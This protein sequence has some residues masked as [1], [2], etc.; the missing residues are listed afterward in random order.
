MRSYH[1]IFFDLDGTLMDTSIGV[2]QAIDFI[3]DRFKLPPLSEEEKRSFIGPPIQRSFQKKYGFDEVQ[4]WEIASA[5]RNA[6]KDQFLLGAAPYDG[7][8]DLLEYCQDKGIHT[9][10]ATNKREDYTM[11]LLQHF[12][13]TPLFDCIV[14]SDF[15]GKRTK[16]QMIQM[17]VEEIG[18]SKPGQCLMVGDTEEDGIAAM[19]AGVDFVGV[20]YGFGILP[21]QPCQTAKPIALASCCAEIKGILI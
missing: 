8:Y 11:R 7:I 17:C 19:K 21:G 14:G 15:E 16:G 4:A 10:V 20:T 6:Y 1:A 2:I 12:H 9:G 3:I 5:W 18:C 13:F